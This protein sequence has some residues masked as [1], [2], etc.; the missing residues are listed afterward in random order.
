M[1]TKKLAGTVF[2]V[3]SLLCDLPTKHDSAI[4]ELRCKCPD[5]LM[6]SDGISSNCDNG[7]SLPITYFLWLSENTY[8]SLESRCKGGT[9][10]EN[11]GF[12]KKKHMVIFASLNFFPLLHRALYKSFTWCFW[13][14]LANQNVSVRSNWSNTH[15]LSF[16]FFFG[17][18]VP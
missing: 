12:L 9:W 2:T 11:K 6:C 5:P 7:I 10:R 18:K 16:S 1:F 15:D 13:L 4:T 3:C 17:S 8:T 14:S